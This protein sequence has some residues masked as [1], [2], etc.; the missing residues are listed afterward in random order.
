[1]FPTNLSY[2]SARANPKSYKLIWEQRKPAVGLSA[3]GRNLECH[4]TDSVAYWIS[5]RVRT[6]SVVYKDEPLGKD[7]HIQGEDKPCTYRRGEV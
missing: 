2:R 6:S 7:E 1:M 3:G 5:T 4:A